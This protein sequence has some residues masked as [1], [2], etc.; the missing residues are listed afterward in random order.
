MIRVSAE[1]GFLAREFLEMSFRALRTVLLQA[2]PECMVSFACLLNRLPTKG[3]TLTVRGKVDNAQVNT[4][5]LS[6]FIGGWFR[7]VK[8]YRKVDNALTINQIGLSLDASHTSLL[9]VTYEE[10]HKDTP[11]SGQER[12]GSQ[13]LECHHTRVIDESALWSKRGFDTLISLIGFTGF[14]DAPDSQLSRE[15]VRGTQ[16]T[17]HQLLQTKLIGR[18]LSKRYRSRVVSRLIK[19]V[20]RLK[21][22]VG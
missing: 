7:N 17:I 22:G 6:G 18:L 5:G 10:R 8:S 14:T 21:Q 1:P 12:D 19:G 20:H 16:L 11:S 2:L 13:A 3:L 9:I 15:F 4:E